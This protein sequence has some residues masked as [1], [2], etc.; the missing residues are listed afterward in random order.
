MSC[1]SYIYIYTFILVPGS[2]MKINRT[3]MKIFAGFAI[4]SLG[5]VGYFCLFVCLF[6]FLHFC[7]FFVLFSLL[8]F[9]S[10]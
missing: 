7:L 2:G 8:L 1:S 4:C 9:F 10:V 5:I 6:V 3:M